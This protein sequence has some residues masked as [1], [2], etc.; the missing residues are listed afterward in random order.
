[1]NT[2]TDATFRRIKLKIW[3]FG[4]VFGINII[5]NQTPIIMTYII[6]YKEHGREWNST[7][8]T[9]QEPVSK[10]YLIDFF[11]LKDCETFKIEIIQDGK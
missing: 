5:C 9:C 2:L 7:S 1:M 10:E 11:G 6:H 8:Y 3:K 4:A